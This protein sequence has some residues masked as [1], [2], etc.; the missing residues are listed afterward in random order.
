M[1]FRYFFLLLSIIQLFL[2]GCDSGKDALFILKSPEET[3]IH[4]RNNLSLSDTI[5]SVFFEYIYNGSGVAIGDV[6]NDGLK[7]IFFGGNM[8]SSRLYL[9]QGQLNFRDVTTL[10]G[11]ATDRWC[12]G[13]SFVDINEDGLLD[14][15]ICVAGQGSPETRKNIFYINQGINNHGIPAFKNLAPEMGLDDDGYS[16]MGVFLDY[17]KDEDLD[18]YILTNTMSG[19]QR[20]LIRPI[21]K[22]GQSES[23]DRLYKNIGNGTFIN[24]SRE[25]GILI[26]GH[27]LGIN[28]CD[29]NQDTWPDIYC[30]NDFISNDLLWINNQDGTFTDMAGSYFNHFPYSSMG[31]DIADYNNDG[32]PDIIVLDMMPASN[33]RQ[34]LMIGYK[35]FNTFYKSLE[36]GYHPQFMRNQLQ[37]NRGPSSDSTYQFSEIGYLAGMYKTDWSWAPL[38]IDFDNDGWKDLLISNGFRKDVTNLDFIFQTIMNYSPFGTQE[39]REKMEVNQIEQLPDVKLQNYIYKNN[40]DM[41]FTDMS[42]Q[43]GLDELT[44]TNGTAFADLDNDGDIDLVFNNLDQEAMIYENILLGAEKESNQHH[45]L[46]IQFD[47]KLKNHEY[48]GTK[49]WAF[50]D[51]NHQFFDY[52]PYRGFKSTVDQDIH[53]GLGTSQRIDSMVV[54]WPDGTIQKI[55]NLPANEI[56]QLSKILDKKR[57]NDVYIKEFPSF[58]TGFTFQEISKD[59][60][61]NYMHHETSMIDMNVTYTLIHN[62]S[63]HGF[64]IATGDINQDGLEDIFAGSDPGYTGYFFIQKQDYTFEA[65]K[66]KIDSMHQDMG[67]LFFDADMDDDLDLYVV[68]GGSFLER[69]NQTYQDRLYQ[70][71]GSGIFKSVTQTA[72]PE[73]R[74]S[75]SCVISADYDQDGDLDL[76]IGGR[77][78]PRKYPYPSQSYLLQNNQGVFEDRSDLLDDTEGYLG[79]VNAALFTDINLDQEIDLLIVGEWMPIR[80]L[81]KEGDKFIDRSKQYIPPNTEGWWN[82]INGADLDND[83]D[84]DY[85]VGNLGLNSFFKASKEK[86]IH[87]F[88]KD[89]DNNGT[90]DPVLSHFVGD[91][92]YIVHPK[93]LLT[94]QIPTLKPV[95]NTYEM[96][97]N[98]VF[99]EI[100]SSGDL[101]GALKLSCYQLKSIILENRDG[102][103]LISHILP[104]EAQ[105][106]PVYGSAIEDFNGDGFLDLMLIGNSLADET[107]TGYHDASFGIVLLNQGDYSWSILRPGDIDLWAG[108]DKKALVPIIFRNKQLFLMSENNGPIEAWIFLNKRKY[109]FIEFETNDAFYVDQN[110]RKTELYYGSG[111][112]SA[113]SRTRLLDDHVKEITIVD[114]QGNSRKRRIRPANN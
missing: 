24:A 65:S 71:N 105:F 39:A 1:S 54:Q 101:K 76:F 66:L 53:I 95:I 84:I 36:Y 114:Y 60:H 5:N 51:K 34:K 7:D 40:R 85:V 18:L 13:I 37:L 83:G 61:L 97:G 109:Q 55:H 47:K 110:N 57:M 19:S 35:N 104:L 82:S 32:L 80:V 10:T 108:G 23:T 77:I 78:N 99:E 93:D 25:A 70:N 11:I 88:A 42:D 30:A 72:L 69:T 38:L 59:I 92:S 98:A 89:F 28:V 17:D 49:I 67:S 62:L 14:I 26:E 20:N 94:A 113:R 50:N 31:M 48:F 91:K 106:S 86:P 75:G 29:I 21:Y 58:H 79:M 4:F 107:I 96:Y 112:L 74:S 102:D 52:T 100:F 9:N 56:F 46:K 12:T 3:G 41:T 103:L 87:M 64:G 81:I 90:I 6:N 68:S 43:W 45:F 16:T 73:I 15:Y 111:Y 27:G 2:P 8:V 22:D 44:F 63:Q 33:L